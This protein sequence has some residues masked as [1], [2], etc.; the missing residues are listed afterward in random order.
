[1]RA[2]N[3]RRGPKHRTKASYRLGFKWDGDLNDFVE[4]IELREPMPSKRVSFEEDETHF[5]FS[6]CYYKLKCK[7]KSYDIR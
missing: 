2:W 4:V 7:G 3:R 6:C 5:R 1:M